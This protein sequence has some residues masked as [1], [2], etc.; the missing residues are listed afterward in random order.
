MAVN[1]L[2]QMND[3]SNVDGRILDLVLSNVDCLNVTKSISMLS[4]VD[5][6]H[7]PILISIPKLTSEYL[8]PI[9]S[10]RY[11]YFRADYGNIVP[12]LKSINWQVELEKCQ[13]VNEMTN[14]FYHFLNIAVT[15]YIPKTRPKLTKFPSWFSNS[16]IKIISEKSRKRLKYLKYKNPRDQLEY[17][18]LRERAHNVSSQCLFNFKKRIKSDISKNPKSFWRFV[19][20]RRNGVSN[21]PAIMYQADQVANTGPDIAQMFANK[22]SSVF[23]KV[24]A[25]DGG[26][27]SM[28][29]NSCLNSVKLTERDIIGAVKK[30]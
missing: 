16:L 13:N 15:S 14:I 5:Q 1:N 6:K 2:S 26:D 27:V 8:K 3:V 21:I 29:N 30:A 4:K 20:D 12:Y 7:P 11:N 24:A 25:N 23:S 18:L 28:F 9:I 10:H 17:E 19:K 22:F